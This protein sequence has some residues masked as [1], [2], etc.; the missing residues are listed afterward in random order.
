MSSNQA[1][2]FCGDELLTW[3]LD[4]ATRILPF[5]TRTVQPVTYVQAFAL[6]VGEVMFVAS[7][8]RRLHS[9]S[10][11]HTFSWISIVVAG[12]G[13]G[14]SVYWYSSSVS[15]TERKPLSGL[16]CEE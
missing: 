2:D 14:A 3:A 10:L 16:F 5:S 1:G 15:S 13:I 12:A 9:R 8:F 11:Q 4:P 6:V 7:Q